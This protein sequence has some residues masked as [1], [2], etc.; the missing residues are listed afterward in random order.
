MNK[1][2]DL[3]IEEWRPRTHC[4]FVLATYANANEIMVCYRMCLLLFTGSDAIL[5][6]QQKSVYVV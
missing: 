5:Q 4:S 3:V 6:E 1:V 2:C